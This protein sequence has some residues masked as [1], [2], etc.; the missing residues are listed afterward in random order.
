MTDVATDIDSTAYDRFAVVVFG[1]DDVLKAV[2]EIRRAL[3][4]SGRPIL[5]GHVTVKGTFIQPR[6]LSRTVQTV[7]ATCA[8][9]APFELAAERPQAWEEDENVGVWLDVEPSDALAGLHRELVDA[10]ADHGQTIYRGETEGTFM[11]HL[12]IVQQVPR[13]QTRTIMSA[14]DG[15]DHR[16]TWTVHEV[17]LV[18]RRVGGQW[19]TLVTFPLRGLAKR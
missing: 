14:I 9:H 13:A 7:Q 17:A 4:P 19:E 18:A 12:T 2:E 6:D 5:P 11:P 15:F 3:P 10:L 16:F 8:E 1:S